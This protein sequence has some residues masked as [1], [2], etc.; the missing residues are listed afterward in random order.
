MNAVWENRH[1]IYRYSPSRTP[2]HFRS[3]ALQEAWSL[4]PILFFLIVLVNVVGYVLALMLVYLLAN[5]IGSSSAPLPT[6]YAG[7]VIAFLFI[8]LANLILWLA[9]I[10]IDNAFSLRICQKIE[11]VLILSKPSL[12]SAAAMERLVA[13]D[14]NVLLDNLVPALGLVGIPIFLISLTTFTLLTIGTAGPF[15]SLIWLVFLPISYF[16][17]RYSSKNF[18]AILVQTGK[19]IEHCSR[20]LSVGPVLRQFGLTADLDVIR[21]GLKSELRLRDETEI[22]RCAALTVI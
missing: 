5:V 19:R 17:A 1:R 8:I 12:S 10:E 6:V 2:T 13:R 22:R 21:S 16:I 4:S 3:N 9:Q 7:H 18:E 15:I 11:G 20:W 14:V